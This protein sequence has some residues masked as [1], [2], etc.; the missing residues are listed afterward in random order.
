[1]HRNSCMVQHV[2]VHKGHH[3]KELQEVFISVGEKKLAPAVK[4]FCFVLFFLFLWIIQV[5]RELFSPTE[6]SNISTEKL[7]LVFSS[8][9]SPSRKACCWRI[10]LLPWSLIIFLPHQFWLNLFWG[11]LN[12]DALFITHAPKNLLMESEWHGMCSFSLYFSLSFFQ[13]FLLHTEAFYWVQEG[14]FFLLQYELSRSQEELVRSW[15]NHNML[16][17]YITEQKGLSISSNLRIV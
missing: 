8:A 4:W 14:I 6:V 1:M 3:L 15:E 7:L 9:E 10:T 12:G 5:L 16:W 11:I 2:L 17:F 13:R